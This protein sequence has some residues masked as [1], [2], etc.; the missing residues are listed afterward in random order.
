MNKIILFLVLLPL[1]GISQVD[2]RFDDGNF[3]QNPAWSGNSE[4][5]VI[6]SSLQLQLNASTEGKSYLITES[7]I[8]D[9][10]SWEF[11]IKQSFSPSANNYCRVYLLSDQ[12]DLSTDPSGYYLQFGETGSADAIELFKKHGEQRTS[13]CRGQEGL[14]SSSFSF[15]I[16]VEHTNNHEWK[17]YTAGESNNQYVLHATDFDEEVIDGN[18]FGFYCQY[19]NSNSQKFYFDDVKIDYM[20]YDNIPPV[21]EQVVISS[22]NMITV[23]FSEAVEENSALI[24]SNYII[25]QDD[26]IIE[27]VSFSSNQNSE[28]RLKLTENLIA[29]N[30]QIKIQ[31]ILDQNGNIMIPDITDL[32]Y[33]PPQ[34]AGPFDIVITE[35]MAD[36]NPLPFELPAYDYVE[37]YNT[38]LFPVDMSGWEIRNGSNTKTLPDPTIIAPQQYV[39]L[40]DDNSVLS[41]E[42]NVICF[43]TFS[44]NNEALIMLSDSSEQ[45]IHFL[46][47]NK[48]WYRDEIKSEG[49]WSLEMIDVDNP[50][51]GGENWMASN[52]P[53]GGTPGTANSV[54][55]SNP[56]QIAPAIA[57]IILI[58][59]KLIEVHFTESVLDF[60]EQDI[61]LIEIFPFT[62]IIE[63]ANLIPPVN[64][65]L[66]IQLSEFLESDKNIVLTIHEDIS[67]CAGNISSDLSFQFNTYRPNTYDVVVSEIMTDISPEPNEIPLTDYF[68]LYNRSTFDLNLQNW[69]FVIGSKHLVINE[70]IIVKSHSYYLFTD[71]TDFEIDNQYSFN[72][73][74]LSNTSETINLYTPDGTLICNTHY[75]QNWHND[76]FKQE[77]GWSLEMIDTENPCGGSNNFSSCMNYKGGSPGIENSIKESNPDYDLPFANR[78]IVPEKNMLS[79]CYNEFLHP[80]LSISKQ[81]FTVNDVFPD[82]AF[83]N[84]DTFNEVI[85]E[86]KQEFDSSAYYEL[87]IKA[88]LSDCV[89]NT[90]E[91]Q[92]IE[93]SLPHAINESD[94]I[95]NEVLYN[96]EEN[97]VD[98]VEIYNNG[99]FIYDLWELNMLIIDPFTDEVKSTCRLFR[100]R[101]LI[102]PQQYIV[103][104]KD[105]SK[106]KD[107]YSTVFSQN[108]L[109]V[110]EFPNLPNDGHELQLTNQKG[111]II[112]RMRYDDEMHFVMLS[113]LEG[114]SL[115]R[116]N[117]NVSGM[118]LS[119]WHSASANSG[120]ATPASENSQLLQPERTD[121]LFVIDP[122]V[123]SPDND[124]YQDFAC[125]KYNITE[126]GYTGS[127]YIFDVA[128]N[129]IK[130]ITDNELLSISGYYNWDGTTENGERAQIGP[131]IIYAEFVHPNGKII[132]EKKVIVLAE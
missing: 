74:S 105:P 101:F 61:D 132:K 17:I 37:L 94:I 78:V 51:S 65:K 77:G 92:G 57:S 22:I 56:D 45:I 110:G 126:N 76:V 38:Q 15:K 97:G 47:F 31:N 71:S 55:A 111:T 116:I 72:S 30:Y 42:E 4:D 29:G 40:T 86:W 9:S 13:I 44:V 89:E 63:K 50:C 39:L 119:N 69:Y 62:G 95:L 46:D 54:S 26:I 82:T 6:N 73:L 113:Q 127:F 112:D 130:R 70:P 121:E 99:E 109:E 53:S 12:E 5:F 87:K 93:F 33:A 129:L 100:D 21:V 64:K 20:E 91:D 115:E 88:G 35:I 2:D 43:S 122:Q 83:L 102:Y 114:V 104:T 81:H 131:Y 32:V 24:S 68:E 49:G 28:I 7:S 117:P 125:I 60:T 123:F 1:I 75:D 128:G 8:I 14:I 107:C 11:W 103:F 25:N 23:Y 124:G 34:T 106:V 66:E 96:P 67:D 120:Y 58:S 41:T 80:G 118:E 85:L 52:H 108:I 90:S 16:K 19:T 79:I 98:F 10:V 48:D 84:M 36:V 27:D 18:Y 59:E 3:S